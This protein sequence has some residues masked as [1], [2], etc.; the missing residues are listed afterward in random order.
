LTIAGR[1]R[2]SS[3]TRVSSNSAAHPVADETELPKVANSFQPI[4]GGA[5]RRARRE[6]TPKS[7]I[8]ADSPTSC[9]SPA[10]T[11]DPEPRLA[12]TGGLGI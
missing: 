2:S 4:A 6:T 12:V 5:S 9:G 7:K 10:M 8:R 3:R 1:I 11:I